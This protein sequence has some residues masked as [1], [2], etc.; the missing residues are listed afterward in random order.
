MTQILR[1]ITKMAKTEIILTLIGLI[2]LLSYLSFVY[3]R[4]ETNATPFVNQQKSD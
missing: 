3:Y 1:F 2:C 4:S